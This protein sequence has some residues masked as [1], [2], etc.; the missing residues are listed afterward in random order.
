MGGQIVVD[1]RVRMSHLHMTSYQARCATTPV[2]DPTPYDVHTG[3][4]HQLNAACC[5]IQGMSRL[6][7]DLMMNDKGRFQSVV[8]ILRLF[9]TGSPR[10]ST[11]PWNPHRAM[12]Q[13]QVSLGGGERHQGHALISRQRGTVFELGS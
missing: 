5:I 8:G 7:N 9:E 1:L 2:T 4:F 3:V 6:G 11:E 13:V 12:A 10:V